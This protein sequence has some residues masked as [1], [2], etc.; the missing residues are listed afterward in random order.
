MESVSLKSSNQLDIVMGRLIDQLSKKE[1]LKPGSYDSNK[2]Y[3]LY[4]VLKQSFVIPKTSITKIMSRLL[5][6]VGYSKKPKVMVGAGTY[7]GHALAWLSGYYILGD[8]HDSVKIY[9]LDIS[10]EATKIAKK[11]F[12]MLNAKNVNLLAVDAIE[13][14][15][16]T[17]DFVDLL[18]IDIDTKDDGKKKYVDLLNAAYPKMQSGSLI[19]AHDINEE[20]F[21]EDMIP[22][23][24]EIL[25][26]TKFKSSINLN[27][28]PYGLSISIKR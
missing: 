10:D 11:N 18:Y 7:T 23:I 20:K 27:V 5:F 13:W 1:I 26:R 19:V 28:D 2:F 8:S 4:E 14:F 9:G 21:K 24:E 17:L 25:D 6:S 15:E 16:D 3:E 22:F 12:S